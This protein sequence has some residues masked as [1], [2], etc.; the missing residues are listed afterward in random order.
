MGF[1]VVLFIHGLESFES[2]I[3][4]VFAVGI[5][6]GWFRARAWV[7]ALLIHVLVCMDRYDRFKSDV[8]DVC[9]WFCVNH[10]KKKSCHTLR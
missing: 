8:S 3:G 9:P 2:G 6:V 10:C 1:S 7:S 4:F 5:S